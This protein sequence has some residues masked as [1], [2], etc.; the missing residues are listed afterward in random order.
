MQEEASVLLLSV[1]ESPKLIKSELERLKVRV[2]ESEFI[3]AEE[4]IDEEKPDLVVLAGA[5]GAMELATLLDDQEGE[6]PARMVI[7]AE[8]K[9]LAKLRGLNREVVISLFALETTEKVVAQRVE[10]LARRAARRRAQ[11]QGAPLPVTKKTSL[12]LPSGQAVVGQLNLKKKLASP[13]SPSATDPKPKPPEPEVA[14]EDLVSLPPSIPPETGTEDVS[15]P[16]AGKVPELTPEAAP[17]SSPPT[18][19]PE[20]KA[21]TADSTT[22]AKAPETRGDE[23]LDISDAENALENL[24]SQKAAITPELL[25]EAQKI[26]EA[27]PASPHK[28][29]QEAPKEQ[30]KPQVPQDE[31]Q[32][33]SSAIDSLDSSETGDSTDGPESDVQELGESAFLDIDSVFDD[34]T[35]QGAVDEKPQ[36]SDN[37]GEPSEPTRNSEAENSQENEASHEHP[38]AATEAQ[39]PPPSTNPQAPESEAEL[40]S[41][42]DSLPSAE[43]EDAAASSTGP[44]LVSK[45]SLTPESEFSLPE[46]KGGNRLVLFAAIALLGAGGAYFSGILGP[47]ASSPS[48]QAPTAASPPPASTEPL[49]TAGTPSSDSPKPSTEEPAAEASAEKAPTAAAE[50][51]ATSQASGQLD[52]PFKEPDSNRPSCENLVA[53]NPLEAEADPIQ[54]A[55]IVWNEARKAIVSGKLDEAQLKMCQAVT[56]NPESAAIEGLATLYLRQKS[57]KEALRWADKAEEL[58]PGQSEMGYVRG[59]IYALMGEIE[60]AREIWLKTLNIPEEETTRIQAVSRD[61]SVEAGR[62]LRRGDLVRAEQWFRRAVIL[63]PDNIGGIIGLAKAFHRAEMPKYARAFCEMSLKVSDEIPE[64]HVMLGELA[65]ADGDSEGARVRFERALAVRPGFF[66]AKRGLAQ[67]KE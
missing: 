64:V 9:D 56:L 20:A 16:T 24:D 19:P 48:K 45:A 27:Q 62:H 26:A 11:A 22:S 63:D 58:R 52:N 3:D 12:G 38:K 15:L 50:A 61:Y 36:G 35:K 18:L 29:E 1:G 5:R 25:K 6:H 55:S 23:D 32:A 57:A 33:V 37:E 28:V 43:E 46:K 4:R 17:V 67:I 44:A 10:S 41:V 31:L 49:D 60:K 66:P 59:D 14:D 65:A 51:P 2:I 54:Q 39:S 34:A 47:K 13:P 42:P 7:V 53:E 21:S 8:R 40:D 30:P